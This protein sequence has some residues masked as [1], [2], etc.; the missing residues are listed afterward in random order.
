MENNLLPRN[1]RLRTNNELEIILQ[2]LIILPSQMSNFSSWFNSEQ[3]KDDLSQVIDNKGII[4]KEDI[5][6]LN[7]KIRLIN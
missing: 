5:Y 7:D 4:P 2:N 3:L 1:K 6:S